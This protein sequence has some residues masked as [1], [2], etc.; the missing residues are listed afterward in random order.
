MLTFKLNFTFVV[1]NKKLY[2][3]YNV[4]ANWSISFLE[5]TPTEMQNRNQTTEE[6][7]GAE[8]AKCKMIKENYQK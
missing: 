1:F 5:E 6:E 8:L 4:T 2:S 7:E 3:E